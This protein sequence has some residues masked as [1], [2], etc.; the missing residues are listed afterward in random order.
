MV[1]NAGDYRDQA[2]SSPARNARPGR[3]LRDP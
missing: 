1:E 3:K 2:E